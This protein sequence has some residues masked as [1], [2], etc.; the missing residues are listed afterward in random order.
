MRLEHFVGARTR[1]TDD[2]LIRFTLVL[3]VSQM[4][5]Q[6]AREYARY[7]G[8]GKVDGPGGGGGGGGPLSPSA[9]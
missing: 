5:L 9:K 1:A 2:R 7:C 6:Y 3:R 8:L 4:L